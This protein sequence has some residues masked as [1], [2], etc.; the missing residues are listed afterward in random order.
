MYTN[1]LN[2]LFEIYKINNSYSNEKYKMYKNVHI[3]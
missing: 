1:K 3:D 2:V